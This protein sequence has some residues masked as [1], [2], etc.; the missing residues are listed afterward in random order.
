M[1]TTSSE[2]QHKRRISLDEYARTLGFDSWTKLETAIINDPTMGI[3]YPCPSL[4]SAKALSE[5]AA[6][7]MEEV[8]KE[9]EKDEPA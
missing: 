8:R 2:R 9:W 5:A 7:K 3:G 4:E 1:A 6:R